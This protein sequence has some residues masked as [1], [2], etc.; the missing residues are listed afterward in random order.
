MMESPMTRRQALQSL[1]ALALSSM[2]SAAGSES[3]RKPLNVVWIVADDLGYGDVGCYGC[4]DIPT[5]NLDRLANEGVRATRFYAMPVCSPTRASLLTGVSPHVAGVETAL[6]GEG[7][8]RANTMTAA[9]WF[10]GQG[11]RTGLVGKWHLGYA[12]ASLPNAQGF[13]E[14]FGHLGGKIHYYAHTDE[15]NGVERPDL[16]EDST[17]VQ[18]PGEYT[19]TLFTERACAF[20]RDNT[21]RPFFLML[22]YNAPHYAR[23]KRAGDQLA[24]DHYIQAPAE[25]IERVARNPAQPT[26]REMYAAAV[27]CMDDGIG[28]LL[29]TL[30]AEGL[31]ERT[32]VIFFSDNGADLGHGGSG[33]PLSGQKGWLSEGGIRA[34]FLARLPGNIPAGNV[35]THPADVRD[36]F[37]T[38]VALADVSAPLPAMEGRD[39]SA[40]WAGHDGA[41]RDLCFAWRKERAVMRD[42]WKWIETEGEMHLYDVEHDPAESKDMAMQKPALA[43]GLARAWEQ[44][45]RRTG[46]AIE[47]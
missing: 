40:V 27:A 20:V 12:G 26:M 29:K 42:E 47:S 43:A 15:L 10:R 21:S 37:A 9:K 38:T 14:F 31:A 16:W 46:A 23:G 13:D 45:A 28:R 32:L 17:A 6:M 36:I 35:S 2:Y 3:A 7:G 44:W 25:Y 39:V 41:P 18:R 8:L 30:D 1:S 5:P 4:L 24:P 19:T 11:Y 22:S 33:G 34:V